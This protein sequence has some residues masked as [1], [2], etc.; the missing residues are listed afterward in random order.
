[1]LLYF[2]IS[3]IAILYATYTIIRFEPISNHNS[4]S[5]L[6]NLLPTVPSL[7]L[8]VLRATVLCQVALTSN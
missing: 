8:F 7:C 3:C 4:F 1:M 5:I 2:N 6:F